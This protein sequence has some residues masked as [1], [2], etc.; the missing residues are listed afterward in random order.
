VFKPLQL[1]AHLHPYPLDFVE[2]L[3][4][5]TGENHISAKKHLEAFVNFL[6]NLEIIHEDVVMRLFSKSLM[7]EAALWFS[8]LEA[9]SISSWTNFCYIFSKH[10]GENKSFDQYLTEYYTLKRGKDEVLSIFNKRFYR[11]YHDMPLEIWPTEIVSMVYC[12][13]A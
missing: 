6:D 3:S 11:I 12:V 9:G 7:G 1:S 2:Y 8:D 4:H 10:W 13:M 5:F